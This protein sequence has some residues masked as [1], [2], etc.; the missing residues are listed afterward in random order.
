MTG[1]GWL[2]LGIGSQYTECIVTKRSRRHGLV[3]QYTAVYCDRQEGL[4]QGCV[5]TQ[6]HDT[7]VPARGTRPRHGRLACDTSE[8]PG[9]DTT[10]PGHDTARACPR[11]GQ[12]V[13]MTW[14]QCALCAHAWAHPGVLAGSA[15]CAHYALVQFWTQYCF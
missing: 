10:G 8:G 7:A 3:S 12:G 14:R 9:H 2:G 15:G 13:P 1:K 5:P 6:G 4:R 11:H